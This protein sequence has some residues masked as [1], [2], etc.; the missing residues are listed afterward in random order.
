MKIFVALAFEPVVGTVAEGVGAA[1]INLTS[2]F[3][4]VAPLTL[5]AQGALRLLA[6]CSVGNAIGAPWS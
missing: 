6:G 4:S 1:L 2:G 3:A 5:L